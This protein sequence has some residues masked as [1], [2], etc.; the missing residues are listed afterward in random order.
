MG[1]LKKRLWLIFISSIFLF[2]AGASVLLLYSIYHGEAPKILG[3]ISS[4]I[5]INDTK[6]NLQ[7]LFLGFLWFLALIISLV[8]L[9]EYIKLLKVDK[10]SIAYYKVKEKHQKSNTDLDALYSILKEHKHLK[11]IDIAKTFKISKERAFEWAKILEESNLAMV[12]YPAFSE[13]L[14]EIKSEEV[15]NE[16]E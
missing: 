3:K 4:E 9:K 2:L 12:E 14:I 15:K 16:K 13:P 10:V 6:I 8:S 5:T 7:M 11:I 1:N